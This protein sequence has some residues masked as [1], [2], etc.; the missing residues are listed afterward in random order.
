VLSPGL[1]A[2]PDPVV[3]YSRTAVV[4]LGAGTAIAGASLVLYAAL[5]PKR[6]A[7]CVELQEGACMGSA[8]LARFGSP[9]GRRESP[10][11]SGPP[12]AAL[13]YSLIGMGAAWSLATLLFDSTERMPWYELA[14]GVAIFGAS[15]ALSYALDGENA[16]DAYE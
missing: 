16:V 6:H 11:G 13:G 15:L 3:G 7:V 10:N 1:I 5:A 8:E 14:A 2:L 12:S 9:E 4:I